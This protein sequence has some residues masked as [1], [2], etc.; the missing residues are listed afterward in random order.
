MYL[1]NEEAESELTEMRQRL[2]KLEEQ[3]FLRKQEEQKRKLQKAAILSL[4]KINPDE[5][6]VSVIH[7]FVLLAFTHA[8]LRL[9]AHIL[10]VCRMSAQC[11]QIEL[12]LF[13]VNLHSAFSKL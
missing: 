13:L 2:R 1:Q 4:E 7:K 5:S 3:E 6:I 9:F 11:M 10:D 8:G 12:Y